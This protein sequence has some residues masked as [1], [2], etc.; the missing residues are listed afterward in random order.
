MY[1]WC[2]FLYMYICMMYTWCMHIRIYDVYMYVRT[3]VCIMYTC[4]ILTCMYVYMNVWCMHIRMM[5]V[6]C[7][8]VW[9]WCMY[10]IY[11]MDDLCMHTYNRYMYVCMYVFIYDDPL[12]TH[13]CTSSARRSPKWTVARLLKASAKVGSSRIT[14]PNEVR[15]SALK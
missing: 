4:M 11:C 14:S 10:D 12:H 15:A 3:Y 7:I 8:H 1:L 5:Y 2:T 13:K 9:N 6:W